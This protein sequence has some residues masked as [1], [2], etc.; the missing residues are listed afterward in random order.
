MIG[1]NFDEVV[2]CIDSLQLTQ[3]HK[4]ATPVDWKKGEKCIIVPSVDNDTAKDL[5]P[6]GW[7]APLKYLRYVEDP[8]SK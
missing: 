4:V 2:R 7:E 6:N 3:E 1:R 5:F 8:S